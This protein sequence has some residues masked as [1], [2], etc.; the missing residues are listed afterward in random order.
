MCELVLVLPGE[1]PLTVC[2][3][4]KVLVF[5]TFIRLHDVH[6]MGVVKVQLCLLDVDNVV[7]EAP[8]SLLCKL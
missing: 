8:Q 7:L 2:L 4:D 5:E 1:R 6:V 3:T